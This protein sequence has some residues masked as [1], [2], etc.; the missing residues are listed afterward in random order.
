MGTFHPT[1][2]PHMY[3]GHRAPDVDMA[4]L[5]PE[6]NDFMESSGSFSVDN[7]SAWRVVPGTRAAIQ[8][9]WMTAEWGEFP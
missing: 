6:L 9:A 4:V 7:T 5:L 8:L 2:C 3:M 1:T